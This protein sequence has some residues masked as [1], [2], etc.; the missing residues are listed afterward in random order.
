MIKVAKSI[1]TELANILQRV[2]KLERQIELASLLADSLE[3]G[4]RV[5]LNEGN[6]YLLDYNGDATLRDLTAK[7]IELTD[8]VWDD[9]QVNIGDIATSGWWGNNAYCEPVA[10]YD[11]VA[12]QFKRS[13]STNYKIRFNCQI[14][15][16]YWE[17]K[18]IHF[19]GHFLNVNSTASKDVKFKLTYGW[20]NIDDTFPASGTNTITEIFTLPTTSRKHHLLDFSTSLTGTNKKISS[21]LMCQLERVADSD[22]TYTSDDLYMIGL[23]YHVPMN[24][25]GSREEDT[26]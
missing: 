4:K 3:S 20:A 21:I 7:E 26:K 18:D 22:D 23:D 2:S 9:Q 16:K 5:S 17:G 6:G 10:I 11:G 12:L 19:H 14:S 8:D 13:T 24:T 15:H 1:S 25:L